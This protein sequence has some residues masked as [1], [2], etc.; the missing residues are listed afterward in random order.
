MILTVTLNPA[1]DKTASVETMVVG[2]LN[3]L[4]H[5]LMNAGGKGINVSKTIQALGGV[6]IATGFV[7]GNNGRY[8]T[9]CL[10]ELGIVHDMVWVDGETRVNLKVLNKDNELTE[11]NESGPKIEA[12]FIED[13]C[14]KIKQLLKKDD[15][16]VLSGSAPKGV[17]KNIY[18]TLTCLAKSQGATVLL[19]ADGELFELGIKAKP[20][21][22]KP[23]KY[24]LCKYFQVDQSIANQDLIQ[25]AKGLL[26]EG[27]QLIVISMGKEGSIYLSKEACLS[28]KALK[29]EANSS[30]GAGDAMVAALALALER[31]LT[32]EE[33]IKL[34]VASSAGAVMTQGTAPADYE[35]VNRLMKQVVINP[36]EE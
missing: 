32:M 10:D 34:A 13:L 30:V 18:E 5:V 17:D 25:L 7:G 24:E 9:N 28:S 29:I 23:N 20:T 22:I 6:S 11:L 19:D 14:A 2:G 15:L 27:I 4:D 1:I 33:M 35:T 16:L 12:S 3:R 36:M 31:K 21:V 26:E 8:I